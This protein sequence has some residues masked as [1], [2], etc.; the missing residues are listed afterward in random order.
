MK[1]KEDIQS[2]INS[3]KRSGDFKRLRIYL[4]KLLADMQNEY[5]LLAELSSACYQLGKYDEALTHAH[6][7]YDIAP[8]DYWVRYIYGCALTANDKLEEAAEMFDSII[9]CDV[10][11]LANYEYGEGKRWADSLLNDSLYMRAVVFQQEGCSN[12]ARDM[13]LRHKSLRRRGLYSD[14]SIRQVDN[15]I[16]TL[17]VNISDGKMDYSISKYCPELY[18]KGDYIKNEWT[19]V[20]DIGKSFDDG[21]LTSAEYLRI[22]QCY[23]DTAIELARKSGCS[24]LIIDY[25]EGESHDIILESKKNPINRNLID[26]AKNIRQGLRVRISQCANYLRLCLRECCYAT[27]SNHA[28]NFYVDFGYDFYMHVHTELLKL[29]VENIVKTNNLFIRP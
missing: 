3:C 25:L 6:K 26:A 18:T 4:R 9:A 29:Q 5:Y 10:M 28:H 15:H 27:F 7:A 14:F 13:F 23:I 12:E 1:N 2:V 24:Y 22:E 11:F 20:S 17:D 21:V 16:R 19:S 8:T